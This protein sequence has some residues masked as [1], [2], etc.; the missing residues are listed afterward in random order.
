MTDKT[1]NSCESEESLFDYCLNNIGNDDDS[2]SNKGSDQHPF[3]KW[4]G[5]GYCCFCNEECNWQSQSCGSCMRN[6]YAMSVYLNSK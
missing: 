3:E 5:E 4:K 6:G 1:N 2:V